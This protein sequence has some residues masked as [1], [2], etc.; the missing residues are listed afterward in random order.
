M[1]KEEIIQLSEKII[2]GAA[3]DE[4]IGLFNELCNSYQLSGKEW[5]EDK[6]GVQADLELAIKNAINKRIRE[7]KTI[8]QMKWFR[9][10]AAAA[11]LFFLVISSVFMFRDRSVVK[12]PVTETQGKRFKNDIAAGQEGAILTLSN[13]KTIVIDTAGNGSLLKEANTEIVKKD[14]NISYVNQ[15]RGS[16]IVYNT[17]TTPKGRQYSLTLS[18]GS[19]VWL[20]AASSITFPTSF[21]G[22]ERKVNITG[23]VYFEVFHSDRVP[24]I[25]Q[26]GDVKVQV[27]GTHFN[28]NSYEDENSTNITL[29]EGLIKVTKGNGSNLIKPGQQAQL[30]PT[31]IKLI[32]NVDV[33]QVMAWKNG[34]FRFEKIDIGSIMR[35]LSR[36]YDVEVTYDKKINDKFYAVIPR[37]TKLSEVLKALELTGKVRFEIDGKKIIV[38]P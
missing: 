30:H 28:F 13:G 37:D 11:I 5:Q 16:E 18:D 6:F 9:W 2:S 31:G 10:T 21:V 25:V 33:D 38:L 17:L 14:G 19:K 23:E 24:F 1:T 20:N 27:L 4:E 36:W 3:T 22:S 15:E 32:N 29:L 8:V 7:E 34:I 12:L 26:K 35:Q